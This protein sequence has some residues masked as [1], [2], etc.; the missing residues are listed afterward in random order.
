MV[1][2]FSNLVTNGCQRFAMTRICCVKLEKWIDETLP[3]WKTRI[4]SSDDLVKGI[5]CPVVLLAT[6]SSVQTP[7]LGVDAIDEIAES[8]V[9]NDGSVEA[10]K[11]RW[12]LN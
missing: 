1:K 9:L 6:L 3:N 12:L 4:L 5:H 7:E 11:L 8:A 10:T 2:D